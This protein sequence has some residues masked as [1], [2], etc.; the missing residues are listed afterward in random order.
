MLREAKRLSI[1]IPNAVFARLP[2]F[3]RAGC[4]RLRR[5]IHHHLCLKSL[6]YG[7]IRYDVEGQPAGSITEEQRLHASLE[8]RERDRRDAERRRQEQLLLECKAK[9]SALTEKFSRR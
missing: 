2:V 1:W 4:I 8:L 3:R 7:E 5:S 6:A 9:L